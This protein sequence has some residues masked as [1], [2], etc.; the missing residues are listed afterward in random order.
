MSVA[1]SMAFTGLCALVADGEGAPGQVLLLDARGVGQV[2]G[3]TLP[4]HAPTLMVSLRDLANPE[5]SAPTRVIAGGPGPTVDQLGI[6]DLKGSEVFI[7]AQ[8]AEGRGLRLY[9][10]SANDS[11]WPAPPRR[12]HDPAA[13]RDLRYVPDMQA[14]V[15]D[16][17]IDPALL[18]SGHDATKGLPASL[19]ARIHL[20]DGLLE[21]AMPSQEAHRDDVFEF[22]TSTAP[23]L[24][25]ALTDTLQWNLR[26]ETAAIVIDIVPAAG[27]P[28]KRL[29]L[30]PSAAPH[31]IFISNLP[32]EIAAHAGGAHSMS[33]E[34]AGALHFA[35][36]YTL[37]RRQPVETP[38]PMPARHEHA[39]KGA[40]NIRN[41]ICPPA[42]FTRQ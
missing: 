31:R 42:R 15:G 27:G 39:R 3:I 41:G 6:W 12:A 18:A 40:G 5:S 14:L 20:D 33:D 24:R 8:G 9:Q 30:A 26:A 32:A 7:R 34:E 35:A 29:L 36:Y 37:L 2:R 25:Q 10:P 4:E 28:S 23:G 17:R 16:G 19:A 11:A 21:G 38:L 22:R 1:L 13:W